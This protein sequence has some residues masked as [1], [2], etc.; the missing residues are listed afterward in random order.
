MTADTGATI[1]V[2]IITPSLECGGSE[3]YVSLL[4]NNINTRLFSVC[5]VVLNNETPF[6]TIKNKNVEVIDLKEKRVLFSLFKIKN[7]IK[8]FKPDIVFTTANHLNLYLSIFRRSFP[9]KIKM[10]A[11]E[12]SIVSIN[13]RRAKMPVLYNW[14]IKKYYRRFNFII[15]QSA[16]MQQDLIRNYYINADKT[17]VINNAV[18]MASQNMYAIN[19]TADK[20]YKFITVARL[21]DEKGVERLIRAVGLLSI[22]FQF[23]IIGEGDKRNALQSLVNKLQLQN[24][25]FLSGEKADPFK[26][27]EDADLFLMGSYYEG[28]PNVLLEAGALGIPVIAFNVPGGIPEIVSDENGILVDDNDILG[29]AEAI[30]KGLFVEYNRDRIIEN[31]QKRFP[32]NIIVAQ[33]ENLFKKLHQNGTGSNKISFS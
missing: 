10:V 18:D 15:C 8:K 12:S 14:L 21:S 2:L 23:Y 19:T 26:G 17:A 4:C 29:F 9:G 7:V 11:R 5:L 20:V 28:F 16:Y 27:M 13:S 30:R 25:V 1:K 33:A 24:T 6:Y 31:T 3:K 32:V 22:P